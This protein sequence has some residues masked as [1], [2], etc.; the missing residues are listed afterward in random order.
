MWFLACCMFQPAWSETHCDWVLQIQK[1]SCSHMTNI[2]FWSWVDM[3]LSSEVWSC[4][5]TSYWGANHCYNDE[6]FM[7]AMKSLARRTHRNL[8]LNPSPP[9]KLVFFWWDCFH[10]AGLLTFRSQDWRLRSGCACAGCC[11]SPTHMLDT[12]LNTDNA[13]KNTVRSWGVLSGWTQLKPIK[14]NDLNV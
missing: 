8:T 10:W 9:L 1:S 6:D 5:W 11:E 7:G 12:M 13:G 3:M 4:L 14:S 2:K